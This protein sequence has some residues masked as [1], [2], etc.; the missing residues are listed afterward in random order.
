MC[1]MPHKKRTKMNEVI[2]LIYISAL[3]RGQPLYYQ[4]I[5]QDE[6]STYI[7]KSKYKWATYK[8]TLG[9]FV[10]DGVSTKTIN[11]YCLKV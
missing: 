7:I 1:A 10:T 11:K 6:T 5:R 3:A 4:I 2:R 9:T 8:S